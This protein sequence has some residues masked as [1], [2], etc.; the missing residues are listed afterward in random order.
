[1]SPDNLLHI[2]VDNE[3]NGSTGF[4]ASF[5]AGRLKLDEVAKG[6]GIPN[7]KVVTG[8]EEIAVT[9]REALDA[10]NG[11]WTVIVKTERGAPDGLVPIPLSGIDVKTRFMDVL[12]QGSARG[13][14]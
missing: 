2:I 11:A 13:S 6:C 12:S 8:Q 1:M 4:Q 5:T 3:A 14:G 9:I 7:V 10:E